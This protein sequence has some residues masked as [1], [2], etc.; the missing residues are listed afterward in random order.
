MEKHMAALLEGQLL[1]AANALS[2]LT[3]LSQFAAAGAVIDEAT[4][5]VRLSL[6]SGK[7]DDLVDL[8]EDLGEEPLVVAA[9]SRQLI[10]LAAAKLESL[11]ISHGLVTGA[12]T[13]DE[14]AIAVDRFQAGKSRV[15]LLTL[16]AGAEGLT[17]TRASTM[18]FMQRSW[19]VI[20]NKQA[21][22]RIHRI[23][24]ERH[25]VITIIEQVTPGTIEERRLEVLQG[26][27]DRI[28]EIIRDEAALKRLLGVKK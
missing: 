25:G 7:V 15:I 13:T 16:G 20:Q 6:P 4:D 18:L 21:E 2:Q 12:Q 26:K 28:Q 10:E 17:L 14:R 23:G 27:E 1:T 24:S 9:V 8:L 5:R 3:R 19:S 11:G 22:D